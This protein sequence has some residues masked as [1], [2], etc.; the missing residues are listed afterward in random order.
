M[1]NRIL[2]VYASKYGSTAEIAEYIGQVLRNMGI[3][4]DVSSVNAVNDISQYE[5]IIIGSATRMDKLL[6]EAVKFA[7]KNESKLR[8]M[9]TAYFIV[10]VTMKQNT[11]ENREKVKG[12]LEPLC[13]ICEPISIGLFAG[14]LDYNKVG[15]A[16]KMM[17]KADKSGI[18]E[19]GDFRNWDSIRKWANEIVPAFDLPT[20][21]RS[22]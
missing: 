13:R 2:I 5:N 17:A 18:M 11:P 19:E 12:F 20:N 7:T 6:S 1:E 22:T 21:N 4:V 14:K 10:G 3:E 15:F 9:K 16:W 8:R